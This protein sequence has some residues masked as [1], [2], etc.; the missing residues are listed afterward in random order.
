MYDINPLGP[1]MHLRELDRQA[2]PILCPV[3]STRQASRVAIFSAWMLLF[4]RGLRA[5][6]IPWQVER[7]ERN[8]R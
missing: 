6:D 8:V 2:A 5:A 3:R 4:I 7:Q 1:L